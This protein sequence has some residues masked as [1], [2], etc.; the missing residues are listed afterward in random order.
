MFSD[1]STK[2]KGDISETAVMK[3]LI[4]KGYDVSIPYGECSY[5]L[6]ADGEELRRIQVKTGKLE[7]GRIRTNL[8]RT[9]YNSNGSKVDHYTNKEI[10]D[11]IIYCPSTDE[12]YMV[13]V[14]DAPKTTISLRVDEPKNGQTKGIRFAS[15]YRI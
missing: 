3:V 2:K 11:F 6:I 5:D 14:E 1:H 12:C 10:D 4:Q 8:E 13:S 7:D 15:D 9:R